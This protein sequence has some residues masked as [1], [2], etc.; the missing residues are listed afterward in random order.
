MGY[1]WILK[2]QACVVRSPAGSLE[3][4]FK[5]FGHSPLV[6]SR[7][8]VQP[9]T[10][11]S[12][13]TD[14]WASLLPNRGVLALH[15]GIW[16]S[17]GTGRT[18]CVSDQHLPHVIQ[19]I[20]KK[21]CDN[22]IVW[23]EEHQFGKGGITSCSTDIIRGFGQHMVSAFYLSINLEVWIYCGKLSLF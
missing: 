19:R 15:S 17:Q 10:C 6:L 8:S 18:P 16:L 20:F 9:W 3:K 22:F 11:S 2:A 7:V 14:I 21:E 5:P 4:E 23:A 13:G 12:T 1:F